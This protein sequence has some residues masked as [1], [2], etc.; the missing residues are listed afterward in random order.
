MSVHDVKVFVAQVSAL[1]TNASFRLRNLI[2]NLEG[3]LEVLYES[4]TARVL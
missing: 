3:E 4:E 2:C 1:L